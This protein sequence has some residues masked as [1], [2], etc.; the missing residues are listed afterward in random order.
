ME[1]R[2]GRDG[3]GDVTMRFG[4][5]PYTGD[6]AEH[7]TPREL[8]ELVESLRAR[9][10]EAEAKVVTLE[11]ERDL[12]KREAVALAEEDLAGHPAPPEEDA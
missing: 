1:Y 8:V 12:F 2:I 5:N 4:V 3:D 6:C 10:T 9:L 11:A 7:W